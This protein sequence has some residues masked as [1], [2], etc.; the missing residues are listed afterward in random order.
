ME[1]RKRLCPYQPGK[2]R[3]TTRT[4]V[5]HAVGPKFSSRE[6]LVVPVTSAPSRRRDDENRSECHLST[7]R[8]TGPRASSRRHPPLRADSSFGGS[9]STPSPACWIG[10]ARRQAGRG[11]PPAASTP[12]RFDGSRAAPVGRKL[13]RPDGARS[14]THRS[15]SPPPPTRHETGL[16]RRSIVRPHGHRLVRVARPTGSAGA[17]GTGVAALRLRAAC[18]R[19]SLW[20]LG[21]RMEHELRPRLAQ[22]FR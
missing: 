7:G 20:D 19:G 17:L 13:T 22:S 8:R 11:E 5:R 3:A 4:P 21:K 1:H 9:P 2:A 14:T 16:R 12:A 10:S 6:S 18:A 15:V